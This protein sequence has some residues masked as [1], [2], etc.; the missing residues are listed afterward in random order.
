MFFFFA[1]FALVLQCFHFK[2]LTVLETQF[3]F[4]FTNIL[5]C[6]VTARLSQM[7]LGEHKS[8]LI[9]NFPL[10]CLPEFPAHPDRPSQQERCDFNETECRIELP[11]LISDSLTPRAHRHTRSLTRTAAGLLSKQ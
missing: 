3:L 8:P 1:V 9:W 2:C 10:K 4:V 7:L 11:T 5:F 6:V